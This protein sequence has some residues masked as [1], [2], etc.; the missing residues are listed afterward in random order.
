MTEH[1]PQYAPNTDTEVLPQDEARQIE[2]LF[3]ANPTSHVIYSPKK[4]ETSAFQEMKE[5]L[6]EEQPHGQEQIIQE[7]ALN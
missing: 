7:D 5:E 1:S 3:G 2:Q 4:P 6:H